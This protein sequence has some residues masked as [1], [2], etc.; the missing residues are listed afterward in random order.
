MSAWPERALDV[1]GAIVPWEL[2]RDWPVSAID[3]AGARVPCELVIDWPV[4]ATVP[5][6]ADAAHSLLPG[7]LNKAFPLLS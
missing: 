4:K 1:P 5:A 2:V 3:V 6:A 7:A